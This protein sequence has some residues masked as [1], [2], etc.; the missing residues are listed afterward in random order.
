MIRFHVQAEW[1]AEEERRAAQEA[2]EV[3]QQ[4]RRMEFKVAARS[5]SAAQP[6]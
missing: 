5:R 1:K 6:P 2:E 4:R 3:K